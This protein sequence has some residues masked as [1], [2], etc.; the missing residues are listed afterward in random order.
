MDFTFINLGENT[1]LKNPTDTAASMQESL[2]ESLGETTE[3]ESC[4]SETVDGQTTGDDI[5]STE[6]QGNGKTTQKYNAFGELKTGRYT[7]REKPPLP[8]RRKYR[9]RKGSTKPTRFS[10]RLSKQKKRK[11]DQV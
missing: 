6:L 10:K 11:V 3:G 4:Y 5:M 8:P 2:T 9:R 7:I 1:H